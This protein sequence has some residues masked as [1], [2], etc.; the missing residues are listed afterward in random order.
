M[1]K[2]AMRVGILTAGG[3]CPGLNAVIRA[4]TK[5]LILEHGSEVIGI[6]DGFRGLVE[7][8]TCRLTVDDVSGI[9]TQGGTILGTTNKDDPFKYPRRRGR[10]VTF[11]DRSG[12]VLRTAKR[13]GLDAVVTVGGDGT[14]T[15]AAALAKKGLPVVGVPKTIDNDLRGTDLTFGHD[16]AVAIAAEAIDRIHTTAMSHHRVMVVE[17]MG[18]HAGWLALRAALAS[19]GDVILIPELPYLIER[20]CE[21][22]LE[23]ST[24]GRRF[25]IVVVA[26]GA[27]PR[28]G[29]IVARSEPAD[30]NEPIR[31]GGISHQV[32]AEI[33]ARTGLET[34]VTVLGHVQRGG[35]PTPFDRI[36]ATSLGTH[37]AELVV[38]RRFGRMVAL[39]G[40]RITSVPIT[41]VAG[42]PRLVPRNSPL[43]AAARATGATFAD[44]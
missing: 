38:A 44:A 26:E 34:R 31:L 41:S 40:R 36:L 43:I 32:A 17:T 2:R 13:L 8:R 16:T 10:K 11:T 12:D 5:S 6:L 3:D 1:A 42:G 39:R 14:Q 19:G 9:L 37:A 24:R 22:C 33:E 25:T 21:R 4:V 23:R 15:I 30:P 29:R 35:T 7:N 28:G 27:R 20:V 18:R